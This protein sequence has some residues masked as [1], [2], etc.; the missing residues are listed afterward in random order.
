MTSEKANRVDCFVIYWRKF[1]PKEE[2]AD[3]PGRGESRGHAR[4]HD[5]QGRRRP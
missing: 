2:E 4:R 1:T 5:R 3:H